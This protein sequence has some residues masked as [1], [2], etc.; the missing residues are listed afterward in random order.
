MKKVTCLTFSVFLF[1]C[2][3]NAQSS[4]EIYSFNDEWRFLLEDMDNCEVQEFDDSNWRVLNLPH[5]WS[6]E[7]EFDEEA[8]AGGR[9]GYLPGGIGWYR[10]TFDLTDWND[11]RVVWIDFEGVYMNSSVW[12]NGHHLG[13]HPYGYTGFYYDLTPYLKEG[14]NIIAVKVDNSM[15]PNSRW[16]TGSGI[17]RNVWLTFMSKI[18]IAH[19][20]VFV[21]TPEITD[22][23]A[24]VNIETSIVNNGY[25]GRE[26]V[27]RS[28]VLNK[29]DEKVGSYESII[30]LNGKK[31]T[32]YYQEIN[33]KNPDLWSVESPTLYKLV[34]E[35]FC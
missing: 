10:K 32:D 17:Y 3:A 30:S 28:T 35:I 8:P 29:G 7:L 15:Q 27:L 31:K 19:W 6:I 24:I 2:F 11:E 34:S 25:E 5:D 21:H 20:G 12:I 26:A 18:H 23:K 9:G 14:E 4:R 33:V 22:E 16:Y 13:I 1:L